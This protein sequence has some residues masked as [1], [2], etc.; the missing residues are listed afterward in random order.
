MQ[1]HVYIAYGQAEKI[2]TVQSIM[3]NGN[4]LSVVERMAI[5]DVINTNDLSWTTQASKV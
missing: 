4:E 3:L 1:H 2:V 5:L